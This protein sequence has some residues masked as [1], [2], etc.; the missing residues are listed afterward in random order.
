MTDWNEIRTAAT[1]ARLGTVS[2]AA[3]TL[4]VHRA[5]VTRHIDQ[6]EKTLGAKLFQRHGRGF[7]PTELG[8][9]LLRIANATDAQIGELQRRA[10]G[11]S[12]EL[13]GEFVVTSVDVLSFFVLPLIDTFRD[14]HPS[15]TVR[16]VASDTVL[17]LEY[18]EADAA[19]RVGPKPGDPD[20]VV[21]RIGTLEMGVYAT[22][23][24]TTRHGIPEGEAELAA[25]RFAG[26]LSSTPKA[27]FVEWIRQ[28]VPPDAIAL[29][30]SSIALL[31]SAVLTGN[32]IGF[33]PSTVTE[34]RPDLVE[35]FAPRAEWAEPIWIVTHVDLHRSPKVQAFLNVAKARQD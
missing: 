9:E 32:C 10:R 6:L 12:G 30:S 11:Q 17:K 25:H 35:V 23:C 3:E 8:E 19:F 33:L 4:S 31:W 16:Y 18:G 5:T 15:V 28:R 14:R 29:T 1:V 26:P 22:R 13:S 7:T 20:N 2:A 24:Y 27:P 21:R 34:G